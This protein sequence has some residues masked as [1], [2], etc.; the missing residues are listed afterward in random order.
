MRRSTL[1]LVAILATSLTAQQLEPNTPGG[2]LTLNGTGPAG[3]ANPTMLTADMQL[4][5]VVGG[6][7]SSPMSLFIGTLGAVSTPVVGQFVDLSLAAPIATIVDGLAL[8]IT[9]AA[10]PALFGTLTPGGTSNWSLPLNPNIVG[11][12][13]AFQAIVA[14]VGHASG[15]NLTGA[16]HMT[17]LPIPAFL[18][19]FTGDDTLMKYTLP[20]PVSLYGVTT[21][22]ISVSTNGWFCLGHAPTNSDL[23]ETSAKFISGAIGGA[24]AGAAPIVAVLWED[25]DVG[26]NIATQNC[27][28]TELAPG[29]IQITYNNADYY[30]ATFLGTI[31][32]TLNSSSQTV[33][34]DYSGYVCATPPIEGIIGVSDGGTTGVA[35]AIDRDFITASTVLPYL[36][37]L[38]P[39]TVF[40][41]FDVTGAVSEVIDVTG[42]II[43]F[44]ASSLGNWS[45]F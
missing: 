16:P 17:V 42:L 28:V 30:P 6:N 21:N 3:L 4:D 19:S 29:T 10:V 12:N 11:L 32:C 33:V 2:F 13:F 36:S 41:N 7:P 23:G 8:N 26:N 34:L 43:T 18:Q 25:L 5:L 15:V 24:I 27:T 14:D 37:T 31:S 39:E 38:P 9:P 1:L 35:T 40:Q 20:N 44:A 45:I 22:L